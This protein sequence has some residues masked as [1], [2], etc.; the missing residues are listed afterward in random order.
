MR[1]V[2]HIA[3]FAAALVIGWLAFVFILV[4]SWT[5]PDG[6][7]TSASRAAFA[8]YEFL[9]SPWHWLPGGWPMS[10]GVAVSIA[11]PVYLVF[12]VASR[13]LLQRRTHQPNETGN[14][15]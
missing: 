12:V 1:I 13:F 3:L 11:L 8:A 15:S 6:Y 9:V 4:I 2:R 10:S 14:A 5:G 7:S